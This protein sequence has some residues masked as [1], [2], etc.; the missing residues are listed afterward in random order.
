MGSSFVITVSSHHGRN[1]TRCESTWATSDHEV[2][3]RYVVEGVHGVGV[4]RNE[5]VTDIRSAQNSL[6]TYRG[7]PESIG[8]SIRGSLALYVRDRWHNRSYLLVDPFGACIIHTI[9]IA[10]VIFYASDLPY[11]L[12][13]LANRGIKIKKNLNYSMAVVL[14]GSGGM[15][16][17]SYH[18]VDTLDS[19]TYVQFDSKG[20]TEKQYPLLNR[21]IN[22]TSDVDTTIE[23]YLED[24]SIN[25]N[26]AANYESPIRISQLTGGMDSRLVLGHVV[27]AGLQDDISFYVGGSEQ[28]LDVRAARSLCSRLGLRMTKYSGV[29][30]SISP[31]GVDELLWPLHE[32]SGILQG[33]ADAGLTRNENLVLSGGYGEV[34]R[35]FYS[36]NR[37]PDVSSSNSVL[38]QM[39]G[40]FGHATK[41]S[42]GLWN[43]DFLE[44]VGETVTNKIEHARNIGIPEHFQLDYLYLTGRN[45]YFVG[46]ISRSLSRYTN[47]FDPLYSPSLLALACKSSAQD[48]HDGTLQLSILHKL[49]P[50]LVSQPFDTPRVSDQFARDH[51]LDLIESFDSTP[52]VFDARTNFAPFES[53]NIDLSID[54][55][56]LK[57]RALEINMPY[58]LLRDAEFCRMNLDAFIEKVGETEM[59]QIL[60]LDRLKEF[61]K[62]PVK[63]RPQVRLLRSLGT[64]LAW[65][66]L[67]S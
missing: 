67:D 42:P 61:S 30:R 48:R 35:S 16:S 20:S 23:N 49:S 37:I 18:G 2:G 11:L 41:D 21:L 57:K 28:S 9:S 66:T 25:I 24:V 6:Q 5:F 65:L 46:E 31:S 60:N 45:R 51:S 19:F 26:A 44:S 22:D 1:I 63:W 32:T 10:G 38:R 36:K 52:P 3:S 58:H 14:T 15:V 29:D 59:S 50:E 27:N 17:S 13:I 8:E 40:E 12:R 53:G 34:L 55:T 64:N 4:V 54:F 56:R 47:R 43:N 39:Y 7:E 33:P 62:S